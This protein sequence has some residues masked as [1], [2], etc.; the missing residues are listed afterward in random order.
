MG[1]TKGWPTVSRGVFYPGY[2]SAMKEGAQPAERDMDIPGISGHSGVT[3]IHSLGAGSPN[4][5]ML[6]RK[7]FG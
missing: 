5:A 6:M 2:A 3:N 1:E 7:P 4:N